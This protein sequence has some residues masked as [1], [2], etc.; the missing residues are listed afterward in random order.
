MALPVPF[1]INVNACV[2]A[3]SPW[4]RRPGCEAEHSPT[5]NSKFKNARSYTSTPLDV[6][7][8]WCSNQQGGNFI[9]DTVK[10]VILLLLLCF[11]TIYRKTFYLQEMRFTT[12][13][14][15]NTALLLLSLSHHIW[16]DLLDFLQMKNHSRPYSCK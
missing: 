3:F 2:S 13:I 7:M 11:L 5:F 8:E 14:V 4:I 9:F 12:Y 15:S 10:Y 1:R 6:L 16:N